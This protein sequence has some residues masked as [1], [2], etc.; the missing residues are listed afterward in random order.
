MSEPTELDD[1]GEGDEATGSESGVGADP[2]TAAASDAYDH[3]RGTDLAPLVE[4]YGELSLS[5]RGDLFERLVVSIVRQLISTEQAD[6][7]VADL[8]ERYEITPATMLDADEGDLRKLGLSGQKIEYIHNAARWW[9][10]HDPDRETF[11]TM[12]DGAV[13]GYLTEISGV[14]DWTANMVL[15]LGLERPDVFPVGDYALRKG[16]E[17]LVADGAELTKAEIREAAEPWAPFRSYATLYVWWWYVDE[18][19]GVDPEELVL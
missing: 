18:E 13:V 14:G 17:R 10:E 3:L 7:I 8:R 15:M 12:S 5:T 6:R 11:E 4:E 19:L 9:R 1:F 2:T 16:V